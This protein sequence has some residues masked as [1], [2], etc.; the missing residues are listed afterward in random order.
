MTRD[1]RPNRLIDE[2]SPYLLQHARNPVDWFPWDDEAFSRAASENKPVFL[3]VG[4]SACHWCHVME[5]ES[6]E[7]DEVAAFLNEHFIS[8]KVDR[9]ERP[10]LDAIYMNAVM[11]MTGHG[12]WPMSVFLTPDARPFFGGTY[13]PPRQKRGM[14]GF[15]DI[16]RNLLHAWRERRDEV[17]RAAGD[18]VRAIQ[19]MGQPDGEPQS[20]E[21]D[22]LGS[23]A[24]QLL[25]EA[26]RRYGG[27]GHAPKFPH[28]MDLRVLLRAAERFDYRDALDVVTLTLDKMARG[29]LYDQLGGGFHR[30]STDAYWLVPHFEKMLYDQAL[31]VPAFLEAY[32]ATG[33]TDFAKVARDTLAYVVREMTSPEGGFYSTQDADSEGEEGKFFVWS[34]QEI[35]SLLDDEEVRLFTYCYDVTDGGNWEGTNILNRPKSPDEAAAALH[36][37]LVD[38]EGRL[39][40]AR[41]KLFRARLERTA[42]AR[43][44]KVLVSWNGMMIAAFAQAAVVLDD[45]ALAEHARRAADFLLTNL[46]DDRGR[47]LHTSK[48]GQAKL[49][50]YLDDYAA[51][52]DGLTELYQAT[53]EARWLDAALE[54]TDQMID[55]FADPAGGFYYTASDH[56]ELIV[57]QRDTQDSATPSGNSLAATAL[58]KLARLTTRGDLEDAA[59]AVLKSMSTQ[60]LRAPMASGQALIALD[61]LLGPTR[62]IVFVGDEESLQPLRRAVYDDF[63]PNKIVASRPAEI[64]DH[65]LPSSLQTLLQGKSAPSGIAA[66]VCENGVCHAPVTT[67]EEVRDALRL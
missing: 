31:L 30:Y 32:Q 64:A 35:E 42:P 40:V 13:W 47:L 16:L 67:P 46:R 52:A 7:D 23:S 43:D 59:A 14:P 2:T 12:G 49:A 25:Q 6:F 37:S 29:G 48:D 63:V 4:Y 50:A 53:G 21:A 58:A 33:R 44:E 60:I 11:A 24:R 3:S 28:A 1:G 61:F 65:D 66:Y 36:V 56:E 5:R 8:V 45:P 20:L 54:L 10:D 22:V 27:F 39:T 18:L 62:E 41:E 15:L 19:A 9:E 26:D 55:R 34:K 51:L 17:D 57:R 38:L